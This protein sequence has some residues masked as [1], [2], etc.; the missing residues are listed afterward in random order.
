MGATGTG[1]NDAIERLQTPSNKTIP[2]RL[3][4]IIVQGLKTQK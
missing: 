2:T 3:L 4:T 1:I